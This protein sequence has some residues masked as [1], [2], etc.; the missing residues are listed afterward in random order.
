M[1]KC[2]CIGFGRMGLSH[3]TI[4]SG[5][6]GR[7]GLSVTIS[8]PSITSR[9]VGKILFPDGDVVSYKKLFSRG[10]DFDDYQYILICTPPS[11][12]KEVLSLLGSYKG[13]IFIEKPVLHRLPHNSMSGYVL[14]HA[15]LNSRVRSFLATKEV[16][17]VRAALVT[18]VDFKSVKKGWRQGKYGGVLHEFGGHVLSVVGACLPERSVFNLAPQELSL[19]VHENDRNLV[20]FDFVE[21]NVKFSIR[22]ESA[23][24]LVRKAS[25]SFNFAT[26]EGEYYYDLYNFRSVENDSAG[27]GIASSGVSCDF[28]VRGFEFTNQ[29][30][31]FLSRNGDVLDQDQIHSLENILLEVE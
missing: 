20:C 9:L 12:R 22:L 5:L 26:N 2:L 3:L 11:I 14:Q 7:E 19:T 29:M 18:N 25:Y 28:Y 1:K 21:N 24:S 10:F 23:S 15:P 31:A 30:N 16:L 27:F 13:Y 4:I 6:V 17:E 8:D